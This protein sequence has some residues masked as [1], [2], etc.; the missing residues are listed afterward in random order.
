[1]F[2]LAVMLRHEGQ[3]VSVKIQGKSGP[4]GGKNRRQ[5]RALLKEGE[6][7]FVRVT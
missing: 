3:D 1:M 2:S 6:V 4:I 5:R 7:A